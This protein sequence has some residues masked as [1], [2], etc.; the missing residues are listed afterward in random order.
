MP[1]DLVARVATVL[2]SDESPVEVR[3]ETRTISDVDRKRGRKPVA[4][5]GITPGSPDPQGYVGKTVYLNKVQV[6]TLVAAL[7]AAV[8]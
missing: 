4:Q 7:K 6:A 2:H 1:T 5:L 3:V 8:A